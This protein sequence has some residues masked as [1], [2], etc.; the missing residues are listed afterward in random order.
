MNLEITN[1][2]SE[3]IKIIINNINSIKI[4]TASEILPGIIMKITYCIIL[5]I[6]CFFW[7][8]GLFSMLEQIFRKLIAHIANSLHQADL[9][10]IS[11]A[12]MFISIGIL[13]I[14]WIPFAVL[15]LPLLIIGLTSKIIFK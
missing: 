7:I 11:Q 5:L 6:C 1:P 14:C 12:P 3:A 8:Y 9:S 4:S 2:M 10:Y 13:I 15:T